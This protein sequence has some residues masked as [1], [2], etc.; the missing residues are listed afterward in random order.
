MSLKLLLFFLFIGTA[1]MTDLILGSSE[2][3]LLLS[4]A[5]AIVTLYEFVSPYVY[6]PS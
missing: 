4:T 2:Y 3:P 5:C 6:T 1:G